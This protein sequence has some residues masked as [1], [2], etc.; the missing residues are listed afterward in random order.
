MKYLIGLLFISFGWQM[1]A[2]ELFVMTEPASNMP[3]NALRVRDMNAVM[4]ETKGGIN[5]HNMP[6]LMWGINKNWMV[7][8]A[9]FISN[10]N[11]TLVTEGGSLYAKYRFYSVDDL[12]SHFRLAAFGRYSINNADIHQEELETMGH[13]TGYE[14][15]IVATKLISKV[16]ISSTLSYERALNNMPNYEF[17]SAQ[18]NNAF[19]YTLSVGKLMYPKVYTSLKQTNINAM[20][21][22]LGQRLNGNEKSYLDIVPSIQFIIRSTARIDVGY[23]Q[24]LYST[25]SRTAPN[26]FVVKFEYTF[27]NVVK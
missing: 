18:S 5:Y 12:H 26:G 16:A 13:N 2:Q 1:Q 20:V 4:F 22:I 9:A 27:L 23:R 25:Q 24:Q 10:R 3:A 14:L 15:G 6:E 11:T 17:P 21:E 7:S 19:N 8:A